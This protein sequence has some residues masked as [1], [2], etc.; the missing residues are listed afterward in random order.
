MQLSDSEQLWDHPPNM[1]AVAA[2]D[3]ARLTPG[4]EFF[5][6]YIL[7]KKLHVIRRILANRRT[8]R[9]GMSQLILSTYPGELP[10]LRN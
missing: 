6:P 2:T 3:P 7:T 4:R 1:A 10:I 9:A 8:G 5:E